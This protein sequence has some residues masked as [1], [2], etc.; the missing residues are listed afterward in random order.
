MTDAAQFSFVRPV[1][2]NVY[3]M[4]LATSKELYLCTSESLKYP[5]AMYSLYVGWNEEP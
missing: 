1:I 4:H 5:N 3:I 2:T